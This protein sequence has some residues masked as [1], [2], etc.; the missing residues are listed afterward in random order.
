MFSYTDYMFACIQMNLYTLY[1]EVREIEF[2]LKLD[3]K[4]FTMLLVKKFIE[5]IVKTEEA[6]YKTTIKKSKKI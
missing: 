2:D 5:K 4:K 3:R 1:H 6:T